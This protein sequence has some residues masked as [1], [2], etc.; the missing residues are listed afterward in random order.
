MI[1]YQQAGVDDWYQSVCHPHIET[2]KL[3]AASG[4]VEWKNLWTWSLFWG[5]MRS[6]S[7]AHPVDLPGENNTGQ[8]APYQ[9]HPEYAVELSTKKRRKARKEQTV[10]SPITSASAVVSSP[11]L[12]LVCEK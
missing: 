9:A 11:S 12:L 2:K 6:Y 5:D 3:A 1:D 10:G 8:D 7:L 4:G